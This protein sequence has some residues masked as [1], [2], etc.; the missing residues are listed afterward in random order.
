MSR[1]KQIAAV[2]LSVAG[3]ASMAA[4]GGN[5][6]SSGL[7][8][9]SSTATS[10]SPS[11]RGSAGP[12]S[13]STTDKT[14]TPTATGAR[15]SIPEAA[16]KNTDAGAAAFVQ[17]YNQQLD[18]AYRTG[19]PSLVKGLGAS[20]CAFCS[21]TAKR[22]TAMRDAGTRYDGSI[23][24]AKYIGTGGARSESDVTV[25]VTL[26]ELRANEVDKSGRVRHVNE[27][28]PPFKLFYV[29]SWRADGWRMLEVSKA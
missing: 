27:P 23:F 24:R 20:G 10:S 4:C 22:L 13:S 18:R 3:L 1:P 25:A 11:T 16:T 14:S 8:S 15:A 21:S 29:V 19:D 12:T 26:T 7:T 17:F 5:D 28:V 2:A 6:G 9:T